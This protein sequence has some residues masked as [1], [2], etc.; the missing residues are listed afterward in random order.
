MIEVLE[1]DAADGEPGEGDMGGG[2]ADVVQ[3]NGC[4]GGFGGGGVDGADGDVIGLGLEGALGFPGVMGAEAE[5]DAWPGGDGVWLGERGGVEE[6]L[7]AEVAVVRADFGGDFGE[8]IDDQADAGGAGDGQ[9][10]FGHPA[11]FVRGRILG[12]ELDEVGAALA[13]GIGDGGG[14]TEMEAGGV[15]EGVEAA[16]GEWLHGKYLATKRVGKEEEMSKFCAF[17]DC[18]LAAG[19]IC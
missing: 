4:G 19:G 14:G 12:A 9:D 10:G 6:I 2:P 18:R 11:D 5:G 8:I 3:S 15:N 1:V 17:C 16:E 13:E 7:L